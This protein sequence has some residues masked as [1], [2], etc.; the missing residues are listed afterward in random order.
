MPSEQLAYL[1]SRGH[2]TTTP[3]TYKELTKCP[4]CHLG[5]PCDGEMRRVGAG[6]RKADSRK[7]EHAR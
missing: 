7:T 1:C 6:S 4:A 3:R 2:F 5:Q